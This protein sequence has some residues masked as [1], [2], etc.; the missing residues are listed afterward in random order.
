LPVPDQ[1]FDRSFRT[2]SQG[3]SAR[4]LLIDCA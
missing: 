2:G 1:E 4:H 3:K